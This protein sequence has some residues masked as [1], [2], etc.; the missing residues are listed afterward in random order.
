MRTL[1][2]TYGSG[3]RMLGG[4]RL[5]EKFR[6]LQCTEEEVIYNR[7]D[8]PDPNPL[9]MSA[10][11]SKLVIALARPAGRDGEKEGLSVTSSTFSFCTFSNRVRK[12]WTVNPTR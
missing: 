10:V 11:R 4:E 12:L 6:R 7:L 2:L 9:S 5:E 3:P 1:G 8:W